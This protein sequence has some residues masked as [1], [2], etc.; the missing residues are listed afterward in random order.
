M[1]YVID[2]VDPD[3]YDSLPGPMK[4]M[5]ADDPIKEEVWTKV[6]DGLIVVTPEGDERDQVTAALD[7][8]RT[9]N[10]EGTGREFAIALRNFTS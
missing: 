10:P 4:G 5:K 2:T 6:R 3:D 8:W 9:E 7:N 1:V